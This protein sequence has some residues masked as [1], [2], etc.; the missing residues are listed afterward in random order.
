ME[1]SLAFLAGPGRWGRG[2]PG[3]VQ[4]LVL[5]KVHV[6]VNLDKGVLPASSWIASCTSDSPSRSPRQCLTLAGLWNFTCLPV[7]YAWVKESTESGWGW[8]RGK[9]QG[10]LNAFCSL[11]AEMSRLR[12]T[13]LADCLQS[14]PVLFFSQAYAVFGD[15][16]TTR[17]VLWLQVW[18]VTLGDNDDLMTFDDRGVFG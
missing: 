8:V 16:Y 3:K 1:I 7:K 4:K 14:S 5:E 13:L 6:G 15:V 10:H 9:T 2:A 12:K 18:P 17:V 11:R